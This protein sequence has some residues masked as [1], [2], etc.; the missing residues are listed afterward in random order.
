MVFKLVAVGLCHLQGISIYVN[1]Y[2]SR[3]AQQGGAN[4]QHSLC[5]GHG[6]GRL[7]VV[8]GACILVLIAC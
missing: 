4:T 2:H 6:H 7:V 5:M 1:T 3:A 8:M